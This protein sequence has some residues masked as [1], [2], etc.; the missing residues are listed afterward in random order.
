MLNLYDGIFKISNPKLYYSPYK[1][2][3]D[4]VNLVLK[5]YKFRVRLVFLSKIMDLI[6][7][8]MTT[9]M[10]EDNPATIGCYYSDINIIYIDDLEDKEHIINHELFHACSGIGI[11]LD[12]GIS[13]LN[14]GITQYL[15]FKSKGVLGLDNVGYQLEVFVIEFLIFVYGENII[16]PYFD[17][18]GKKFYKQFGRCKHM[19]KLIN[20]LLD[21]I[22]IKSIQ[23]DYRLRYLMASELFKE[24]VPD[25]KIDGLELDNGSMEVVRDFFSYNSDIL[26]FLDKYCEEYGVNVYTYKYSVDNM[27]C[28]EQWQEEYR[29]EVNKIFEYIINYLLEISD[30]YGLDRKIVK[31]FVLDI[32]NNKDKLTKEIYG[33]VIN[34]KFDLLE[35]SYYNKGR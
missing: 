9:E 3:V 2:N 30:Y 4:E 14:E 31:E 5:N 7:T 19:V 35:K 25:Y 10:K 11:L 24:R 15:Y 20:F 1:V 22:N 21:K 18:N 27:E 23:H 13:N 34:K 6:I 8:K 12:D 17:K 29:F 26:E 16:K 33:D 28:Y 32:F